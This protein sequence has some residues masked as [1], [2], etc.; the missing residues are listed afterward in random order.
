MQY[1]QDIQRKLELK[2]HELID[3][4]S[5]LRSQRDPDPSPGFSR[6]ATKISSD[7]VMARLQ[8]MTEAELLQL[9]HVQ[10]R[11]RSGLYG[12]CEHCGS[13]ISAARLRIMPQATVCAS[14]AGHG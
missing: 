13:V 5:R 10:A 11:L 6:Q 12:R 8:S 14:C 9:E 1:E 3:R 4:L 2:Q 7:E